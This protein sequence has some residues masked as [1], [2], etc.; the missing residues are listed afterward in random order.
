[1]DY[2]LYCKYFQKLWEYLE[3]HSKPQAQLVEEICEYRG[4]ENRRRWKKLF[5][6]VG[7]V[8]VR[9]EDMDVYGMRRIFPAELGIFGDNGFLLDNTYIIPVKDM[10]G[11]IIALVGWVPGKKYI[12]TS[13]KYFD[14]ASLFFGLEQFSYYHPNIYGQ[15]KLY[16]FFIVE[17]IFD[18]LALRSLGFRCLGNM[19][20][21]GS[22][23][24][25]TLMTLC[26]KVVAIPDGDKPGRRVCDKNEWLLPLNG[27]YVVIPESFKDV[28]IKDVD[29]LIKMAD[30]KA[31]IGVFKSY[32]REKKNKIT[33]E[34]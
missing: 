19:G 28:G 23:I 24:K 3:R 14:K 15:D 22:P 16:S 30:A 32:L 8:K 7:L 21:T 11:N 29:D 17:G 20:I 10:E 9:A 18:C 25:S 27:T 4:Y 33:M 5:K 6:E 12:T 34:L 13:S 1:M 31:I 2:K 26:K